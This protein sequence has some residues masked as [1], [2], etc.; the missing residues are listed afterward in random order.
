MF[1][2]DEPLEETIKARPSNTTNTI[3][4]SFN[5][6][7]FGDPFST[8]LNLR[9]AESLQQFMNI[10]SKHCCN[11]GWESHI[12]RFCLVIT[13]LLHKLDLTSRHDSCCDFV[14]VQFLIVINGCNSNLTLGYIGVGV[15]III[16][17]KV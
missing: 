8:N 3:L 1:G 5:R 16:Q 13:S 14:A 4:S 17:H 11:L 7:L 6:C 15:D 12:S 9:L 10:T 2:C